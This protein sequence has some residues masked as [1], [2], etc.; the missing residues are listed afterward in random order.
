MLSEG[1]FSVINSHCCHQA[2]AGTVCPL[3]W[4]SSKIGMSISPYF[5]LPADAKV[6]IIVELGNVW[7]EYTDQFILKNF[8][9]GDMLYVATISQKV[10][11]CVA[12]DRKR[13]Q[14]FISTLLVVPDMRNKGYSKFLIQFA[15][16]YVK[17]FGFNESRLWCRSNLLD[18]YKALGY[19]TECKEG[20]NIVMKKK[21]DLT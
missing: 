21:L 2:D 3:S 17:Q 6:S 10:V 15:E 5:D 8:S 13:F 9:C 1:R 20:E 18:F 7:P 4:Y 14:P 11:G 16:Q 12:V 19:T